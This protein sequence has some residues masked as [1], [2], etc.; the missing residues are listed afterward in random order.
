MAANSIYEY[1]IV[2]K[3]LVKIL[4]DIQVM[5]KIGPFETVRTAKELVK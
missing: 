4:E 2:I 1:Q 3:D 5:H